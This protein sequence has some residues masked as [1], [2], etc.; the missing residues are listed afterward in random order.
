MKQL[1]PVFLLSCAGFAARAQ[2]SPSIALVEPTAGQSMGA[3]APAAPAAKVKV[4]AL[5]EEMPAFKGGEKALLLFMREKVQYPAEALQ[6][7]VSGKV[8]VRFVVDEQ[9]RIRD[10]EAGERAGPRPRPGSPAPGAHHALVDARPRPGPARARALHPP[11]R[12]PH[13]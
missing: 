7:N 8:Y 10:A 6:Q 13:S 4:Y 11:R 9:G 3:V 12:L 2:P 5:A 1:L